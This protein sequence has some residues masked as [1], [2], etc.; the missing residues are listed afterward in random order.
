MRSLAIAVVV[1]FSP[2]MMHA[3]SGPRWSAME[4]A[5]HA[6]VI[7]SGRVTATSTAW[8][9]NVNA[10]Y[11]YI[12]LDVAEVLKGD[13][14]PGLLTVKQL[15][16]AVDGVVLSITDQATFRLGEDVLVYLESRPRDGTLYT[17][18]LWQGKWELQ[19]AQR[20]QKIAVRRSPGAHTASEDR[21]FLSDVR[22]AAAL[23]MRSPRS[24]SKHVSAYVADAPLPRASNGFRLL[25]P[26]R[27]LYSPVV[28]VQ[29]G[30]QP[31]LAGGGFAE[32]QSA[33][34]RWN[35]AGSSFRYLAGSSSG[36]PRCSGQ[37]V[38]DGRVTIT[39]MDPCGEM[40]DTGGT[41]ALGGSYYMPGEGGSVN[42]QT[43]ERAVEGF[44]VNND[45][46]T[47]LMYLNNPGCFEEV[48]THELG[49]VLGLDHSHD[50][51]ALMYATIDSNVCRNGARGLMADDVAGLMFI[52]GQGS[53][54]GAGAPTAPPT[55]VRV[56]MQTAQLTVT[57]RD[58]IDNG[59]ASATGYRIDFRSGHRDDGPIVA[60]L[61]SPTTSVSVAVPAD[62]AGAFNVVVMAINE[63]GAGPP[64]ERRDFT[65]G[66][67]SG[68]CVAPPSPVG[69]LA[70]SINA[71][72]A[73]VRWSAVPGAT[74]YRIQ[75][76][77]APGAADLYAITD[78]GSSTQAGAAVPAGFRGWIRVV[79]ANPCGSSLPA[80]IFVQ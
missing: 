65:L 30:G 13:V 69:D 8:D 14:A 64:S 70:G 40:S 38:G 2:G 32:V 3:A 36:A 16:G 47:A 56:A 42:G 4:L 61:T 7:V 78:L 44:I 39:F 74:S 71:G 77:S 76:G 11:T 20:G 18:A 45:S 50:P 28:D 73:S 55:D 19:A 52:Y 12:T 27:Y 60:S 25:G 57:W 46:P 5:G 10:I 9:R 67:A 51:G 21:Q 37:I 79:A 80:D 43:F 35:N 15:G 22:T 17:S 33:I 49:H 53:P 6:D 31:G 72:F 29:A 34:R 66:S 48:Q 59:S 41:L 75:A 68:P 58:G 1:L 23:A 62:V 63:A 54:L 26:F 24:S